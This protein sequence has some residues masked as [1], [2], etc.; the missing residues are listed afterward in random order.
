[1]VTGKQ[2]DSD[3][4]HVVQGMHPS[5][6]IS[7]TIALQELMLCIIHD[8]IVQSPDQV[9]GLKPVQ[10]DAAPCML[11]LLLNSFTAPAQC[12]GEAHALH[13]PT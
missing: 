10:H 12:R 7:A 2:K 11:H 9:C 8:A 3:L 6:L 5:S 4:W 1:M 13:P